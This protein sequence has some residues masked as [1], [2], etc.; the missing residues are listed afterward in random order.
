LYTDRNFP[1][2]D[3]NA[4]KQQAKWVRLHDV[5]VSQKVMEL[6]SLYGAEGK[7]EK[8]KINRLFSHIRPD[9]IAQ[10]QLGDCWLLASLATL[11]ERPHL[12]QN[13]FLTRSY[14]PRGKYKLRLFD[15]KTKAFQTVVVDD[16]IPVD[17]NNSPIYTKAK[18]NV[19]WPLLIEK[20]FAKMRGGYK[21]LDGG[22][23][24][25][26]MMTMTGY[27][28]ER[29]NLGRDD[30]IFKKIKAMQDAGCILACGSKGNDNTLKEGRD[31]VKG[32]VVGGHAYSILGVYEPMLSTEKVR[33][34]K[35]RNPW[36]SFE[37][38]GAWGD[39]SAEWSRYPGVALEI[40]RP[41]DKDD[42]VFYIEWTDFVTNYD[43]VDVLFPA[44]AIEELHINVH[45]E[46]DLC[47]PLMGCMLGLTRFICLCQGLYNL[48]WAK[49]SSQV[50][51]DI[52][53]RYPPV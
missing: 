20:A 36:G 37:W 9:D 38:Q 45:E 22:L 51:E 27:R 42:G 3:D 21:K 2:T 8:V 14:N 5:S 29:F 40:G 32:S 12:L 44:V 13:I 11:A 31:K 41:K 18:S 19:M 10:G 1:C 30:K 17:H 49:S 7:T 25:D 43:F 28:G 4:G 6:G 23:P 53:K 48:W 16:F 26:A 52:E 39:K 15:E 24:L 33:L 34:I 50:R 47:G 46:A 35:L